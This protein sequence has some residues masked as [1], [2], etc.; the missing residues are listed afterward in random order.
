MG[1]VITATEARIHFGELMREVV[2]NQQPVIVERGGKPQVVVLS[3]SEY[4]NLLAGQ[5]QREDWRTLLAQAHERIRAD[6]GDRKLPPPEDI[7]REMREERDAQLMD[8]R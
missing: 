2:E 8:L 6:L 5:A 1:R 7:I 3:I 4:E